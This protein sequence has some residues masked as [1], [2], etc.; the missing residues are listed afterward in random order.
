MEIST[1]EWRKRS[2]IAFVLFVVAMVG[3]WAYIRSIYV[4]PTA[5]R[6]P[7]SLRKG[8]EV[9][10][11]IAT[12][13]PNA[14]RPIRSYA[15][16]LATAR[17]RQNAVVG[18]G[19]ATDTAGYRFY[20]VKKHSESVAN[21]SKRLISTSTIKE[22]YDS[23]PIRFN[24][25]SVLP[26]KEL[27]F[28]FKCVEGWSQI[29]WWGGT[30]IRDFMNAYH[31]GSKNGKP[32]LTGEE[33]WAYKYMG[34]RSMDGKY[35][36]GIDMVSATHPQALL[37]YEINGVPLPKG[38]GAPLRVLMPNKYGVKSLMKI[39]TI[40]FSDTRPP[41]YWYERGYAYDLNL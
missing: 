41:D 39:G 23:I 8:L 2:L 18:M 5:G 12:A 31:L 32:V 6:I 20:I 38:Q 40:E 1:K 28:N 34:V 13:L 35:Y 4:G 9:N 21:S 17:P 19:G 30:P 36:V 14:H 26:K 3:G 37:A 25:V 15:R 7:Q 29:T 16:N 33:P 24:A 10:E 27:V 11:R 22:E